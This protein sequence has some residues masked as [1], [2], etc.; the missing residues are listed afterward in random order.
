VVSS[1]DK[2]ALWP[3]I[4]SEAKAQPRIERALDPAFAKGDRLPALLKSAACSSLGWPHY[5]Q[6]CLFDR[7]RSVGEAPTI[8]VIALR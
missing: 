4:V 7:G 6:S 8:R 2:A 3:S 5:A 1:I